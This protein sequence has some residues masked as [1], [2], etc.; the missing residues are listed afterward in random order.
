MT[1]PKVKVFA[2]QNYT[3]GSLEFVPSTTSIAVYNKK[4][5]PSGRGIECTIDN[6]DYKV[7]LNPMPMSKD[8]TCVVWL[9]QTTDKEEKANM[10]LVEVEVN[11]KMPVV[12]KNRSNPWKVLRTVKAILTKDVIE[13]DELILYKPSPEAPKAQKRKATSVVID[14]KPSKK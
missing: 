5:P 6:L 9:L 3:Q 14:S 12:Q 10:K 7:V 1:Q 11:F 8:F 4:K 2:K 13:M